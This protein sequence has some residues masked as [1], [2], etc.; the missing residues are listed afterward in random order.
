MSIKARLSFACMKI[1]RG[2]YNLHDVILEGTPD[3]GKLLRTEKRNRPRILG[4]IDGGCIFQIDNKG[5]MCLHK[6]FLGQHFQNT[7]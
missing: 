7:I 4:F 3:E 1:Q 2:A 6:G 5:A